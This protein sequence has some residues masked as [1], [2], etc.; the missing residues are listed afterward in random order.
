MGQ[1][2]APRQIIYLLSAHYGNKKLASFNMNDAKTVKFL[3]EVG[4]VYGF[5]VGLAQ[6]QYY[7]EGY[8]V[9]TGYGGYG[10][11]GGRGYGSRRYGCAGT[12]GWGR[13]GG[14][15][16]YGCYGGYG[17]DDSSE[18]EEEDEYDDDIDIDEDLYGYGHGGE[19]VEMEEVHETILTVRALRDLDGKS[20]NTEA[21]DFDASSDAIPKDMAKALSS[22]PH[23]E[24]KYSARGQACYILNHSVATNPHP[25][26]SG[27]RTLKRCRL[28]APRV[29]STG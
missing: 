29:C 4:Q 27:C 28:S 26:I 15:A 23:D 17:F 5:H 19:D 16:R 3:N 9:S 10:G 2:T 6:A 24:Q 12:G 18:G 14:R 22:Q 21:L 11:Y 1:Q 13:W 8:G 20:L 7:E 25:P